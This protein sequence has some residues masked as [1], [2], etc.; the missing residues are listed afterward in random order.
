MGLDGEKIKGAKAYPESEVILPLECLKR[1]PP[2]MRKIIS[3]LCEPNP[4]MRY[5]TAQE[6]ME[7]LKVYQKNRPPLAPSFFKALARIVENIGQVKIN[8]DMSQLRDAKGREQPSECVT[9]LHRLADVLCRSER[10]LPTI[11]II[12]DARDA[13]V[14]LHTESDFGVV[15]HTQR[16]RPAH[17][18]RAGAA[19]D[20]ALFQHDGDDID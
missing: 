3:R 9:L 16:C 6:A 12:H 15:V 7:D 13:A 10:L 20:R 5:G 1:M 19:D 2:E 4:Q 18:P 11:G 17:H 8:A 14:H